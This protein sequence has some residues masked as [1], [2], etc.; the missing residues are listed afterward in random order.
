MMVSDSEQWT[1]A[2]E[3]AATAA[4][5]EDYTYVQT[6]VPGHWNLKATSTTK[7]P[8][9][10][11]GRTS[12]FAYEEAIDDWCDITELDPQKRGPALKNNLV[13]IAAT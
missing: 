1:E 13:D 7:I 8:P 3:M 12:W 10:F 2:E 6:D 4:E 11:T 9:Q 5:E